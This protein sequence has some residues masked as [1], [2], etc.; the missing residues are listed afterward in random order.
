MGDAYPGHNEVAWVIGEKTQITP[1]H[2]CRSADEAVA[3]AE[4]TR[5]R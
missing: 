2:F 4:M 5:G 3:G 1:P